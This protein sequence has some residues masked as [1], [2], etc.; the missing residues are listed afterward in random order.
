MYEPEVSRKRDRYRYRQTNGSLCRQTD[1]QIEQLTDRVRET[2]S[3]PY[4]AHAHGS[5]A[6]ERRDKEQRHTHTHRGS[7]STSRE[8]TPPVSW[9]CYTYSKSHRKALVNQLLTSTFVALAWLCLP[10]VHP[11]I[12]CFTKQ[13]HFCTSTYCCSIA[14]DIC[15]NR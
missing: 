12:F 13:K 8:R 9:F 10:Y 11:C 4:I 14:F 3:E 5:Q 15:S 2:E 1:G 7:F 6:S